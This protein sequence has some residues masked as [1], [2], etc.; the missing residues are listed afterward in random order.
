M[1][2]ASDRG[3]PEQLLK[4]ELHIAGYL[5]LA[6]IGAAALACSIV[7]GGW[8]LVASLSALA[9]VGAGGGWSCHRL[10]GRI[11]ALRAARNEV[12]RPDPAL[13]LVC[14]S[15]DACGTELRSTGGEIGQVQK[16]LVDAIGKLTGGFTALNEL[17]SSQHRIALEL[18]RNE[19]G[20]AEAGKL[21]QDVSF[22]KFVADTSNTLNSF[23]ENVISSSKEAMEIVEKMDAMKGQID[24]V[25]SNLGEIEAISRQTNLLALNAAIEAAR[26]G[27]HGRGFAV[28]ADEVRALSE[29]TQDFS[30]QIRGNMSRM[31]ECIR[32]MEQVI[33]QLASHDLNFA[34]ESKQDVENAMGRIQQLNQAMA[35][36]VVEL[37]DI[38]RRVGENVNK[39]VTTL[40]FQDL[41]G[42]LLSHVSARVQATDSVVSSMGPILRGLS[43]RT[44][45][46]IAAG[47]LGPLLDRATAALAKMRQ[48]SQRTSPVQQGKI[49]SGS[50]ELF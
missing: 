17:A 2:A 46:Q 25:A 50:V 15:V 36:K 10:G 45:A 32:D 33:N 42:Q 11:S 6:L 21:T 26:A 40:Q 9:C 18:T 5:G 44:E 31:D 14:E 47:M 38:T 37:A 27:E 22:E 3:S 20:A 28:V 43:R 7:S 13:M 34:L 30:Q 48:V 8:D 4:A 29:R 1:A 39:T 23:V 41:S 16:L 35:V 12:N 24:G 19:L 49:E